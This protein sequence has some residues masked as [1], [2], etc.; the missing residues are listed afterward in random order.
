MALLLV[1][2]LTLGQALAFDRTLGFDATPQVENRTI[3]EMHQAALTEG[4]TVVCLHGGDEAG[5]MDFLRDAFEER[6]PG[7]TLDL[8]V[9]LSKYHDGRLDQQLTRGNVTV[10]SIILQT[11]HDYP[12][13]ARAGA[14]MNYAPLGFDKVHPALK[15]SVSASYYGLEIFFW[16][17]VWSTS[18]LPGANMDS[19]AEFVKPEYKNKLVLTYP[20]DDDAVLFAFDLM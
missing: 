14:L 11:V 10:D 3:E 6:F 8:T 20:N 9:D 19:F 17:N 12:R 7:M 1:A 16:S 13:W 4:G 15:D 5:A 18:K 2:A